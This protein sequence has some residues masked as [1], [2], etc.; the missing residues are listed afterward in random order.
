MEVELADFDIKRIKNIKKLN[1]EFYGR[2]TEESDWMV[3]STALRIYEVELK[4]K[5]R[6]KRGE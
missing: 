4:Q 3:I 1:A 5:L 2:D 6:E